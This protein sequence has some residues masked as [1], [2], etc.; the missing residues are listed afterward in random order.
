MVPDEASPGEF[1]LRLCV[2]C[3]S[4]WRPFLPDLHFVCVLEWLTFAQD[5]LL[6]DAFPI[7][8]FNISHEKLKVC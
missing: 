8:S 3:F 6:I 2:N 7:I 5:R 4:A 1:I